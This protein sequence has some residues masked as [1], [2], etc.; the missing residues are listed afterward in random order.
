[1]TAC[2]LQQESFEVVR[3]S[4]GQG[5]KISVS[6]SVSQLCATGSQAVLTVN[7]SSFGSNGS[8]IW[9]RG[10][11]GTVDTFSITSP[12]TYIVEVANCA[13]SSIDTIN[14]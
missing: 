6:S 13:G 8:I 11:P 3:P 1:M 4:N 7:A 10:I 9:D 2:G 12:G 14:C 5:P